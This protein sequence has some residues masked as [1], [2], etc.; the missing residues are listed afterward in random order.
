MA[1]EVREK[2]H[3][4]NNIRRVERRDLLARSPRRSVGHVN[5][6][7][8]LLGNR[9][10]LLRQGGRKGRRTTEKEGPTPPPRVGKKPRKGKRPSHGPSK[11]NHKVAPPDKH[12]TR[13]HGVGGGGGRRKGQGA[14]LVL[15]YHEA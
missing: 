3:D 8:A 14:G 9:G 12:Q 5:Y 13:K 7:G 2:G 1:E 15:R 4:Q 11:T 6:L 10:G